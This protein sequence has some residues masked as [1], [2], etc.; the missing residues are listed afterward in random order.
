MNRGRTPTSK[1][2]SQ[3]S[4]MSSYTSK[5]RA[6]NLVQAAVS[7]LV[8]ALLCTAA[9]AQELSADDIAKRMIRGDA[10]AWEGAKSS[11]RMVLID[12][13]GKRK[14]RTMEILGRRSGG[15][16]QTIVRFTSPS[17]IAGTAFLM[18]ER[19]GRDSEQY[20]YLS[21]LKRT[22]RVV[23]RER[24][25]TFMGSDFTYADMQRVD[26]KHGKNRRLPDEKLGNDETYVVETTLAKDAPSPYSK[27]VSWVRKRDMVALRTRFYDRKGKLEKT[28]Y[29]RKVRKLEGKPVVVDARMQSNRTGHATDLYIDS[30][31]RRDDLPDVAFTPAALERL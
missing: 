31:E 26:A 15:L 19:D 16:L 22:R 18:L 9:S 12:K 6:H 23:G 20:I 13:K 3:P 7:T 24:E 8:C 17:E 30:V 2:Y 25:S 21:R 10:F 14:Q 5:A 28:L 11:I 4:Q 27:V 29:A 1:P